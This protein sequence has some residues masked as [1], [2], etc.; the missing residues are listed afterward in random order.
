MRVR[1]T[2]YAVTEAEPLVVALDGQGP[3]IDGLLGDSPQVGGT[4]ADGT[5]ITAGVPE[6]MALHAGA[7]LTDLG[8]H[9][10]PVDGAVGTED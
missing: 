3:R 2:A 5:R 6:P 7:P 4:R 1:G 8:L 10:W 9:D